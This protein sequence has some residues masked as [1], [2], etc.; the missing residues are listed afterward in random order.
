MMRKNFYAL[1]YTFSVQNLSELVPSSI[2]SRTNLHYDYIHVFTSLPISLQSN[3]SST[4]VEA[5]FKK[6]SYRTA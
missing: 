1:N 4:E 6:L 5:F 3:K 2:N